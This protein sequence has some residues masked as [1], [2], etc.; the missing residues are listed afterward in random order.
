MRTKGFFASKLNWLGII[1][2]LIGLLTFVQEW[3]Q[4][5]D[6]S[7]MGIFALISGIVTI[8]L[9]TFFTDTAIKH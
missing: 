6:Y 4:N 7:A 1:T 3:V 9:R 8:I 5:G 2:F